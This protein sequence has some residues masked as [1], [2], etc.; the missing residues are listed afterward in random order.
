MAEVAAAAGFSLLWRGKA[1][2]RA[3]RPRPQSLLRPG[4]S[5][6]VG[7]LYGLWSCGTACRGG[8]L[9]LPCSRAVALPLW[10]W[11]GTRGRIPRGPGFEPRANPATVMAL[12]AAL[13][14][15]GAVGLRAAVVEAGAQRPLELWREA[16]AS[17]SRPFRKR[18]KAAGLHFHAFRKKT[19]GK[20]VPRPK[21]RM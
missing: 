20:M 11:A 15:V 14:L 16:E 17:A 8:R 2:T 3:W 12:A 4:G 21:E 5:A 9:F 19:A 10:A 6:L 1:I 13:V 7:G 18:G